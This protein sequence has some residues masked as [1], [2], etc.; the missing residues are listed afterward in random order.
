MQK[1]ERGFTLI[2]LIVILVIASIISTFIMSILL[3]AINFNKRVLI[4]ANQTELDLIIEKIIRDI[5]HSADIKVIEGGIEILTQENSWVV[6]QVYSSSSGPALG[7]KKEKS[8]SL[9]G[10][11]EYTRIDSI[12]ADIIDFSWEEKG[13][14]LY[15]RICQQV[16][17]E[18]Q[19]CRY[20]TIHE[21]GRFWTSH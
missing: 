16:S 2:E 5:L 13:N 10:E 19:M 3:N 15:L 9:T 12:I 1:D 14:L 7:Y 6:Y 11:V 17:S 8:I 21:G 20:R 4:Q 18:E